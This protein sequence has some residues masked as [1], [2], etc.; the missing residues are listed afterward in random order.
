MLFRMQCT[1]SSGKKPYTAYA[2]SMLTMKFSNDLCL[3]CST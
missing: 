3:E 2:P 1:F